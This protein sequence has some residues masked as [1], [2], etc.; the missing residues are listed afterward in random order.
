MTKIGNETIRKYICDEFKIQ[1]IQEKYNIRSKIT[2]SDAIKIFSELENIKNPGSS[3]YHSITSK[4]P[5]INSRIINLLTNSLWKT[6]EKNFFDV[7]TGKMSIPSYR[8]TNFPIP[9]EISIKKENDLYYFNLPMSLKGSKVSTTPKFNLFFGRDRS[10]NKSIVE[11]ILDNTYTL[12]GSTIQLTK[13]ND[14]VL[15]LVFEHSVINEHIIDPNKIMGVDI[16]INR[17]VSFYIPDQKYQ[18]KQIEIGLKIQHERIKL[19]IQ[20]KKLQE[21]NKYSKGGH[22]RNRKNQSLNTHRERESNWSTLM[23]HIISRELIK[24]AQ[25]NNVGLIKLED[26]TGITKN[27]NDSFLKTWKYDQ[28]QQFIKYKA[29]AVGIKVEYVNP[30]NTSITCPTCNNID[31]NN[32]SDKDK[33]IF[34]CQNFLCDD[35]DKIKDADIIGSINIANSVSTEVKLKSKKGKQLKYLKNTLEKI[36]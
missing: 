25:E 32:R 23:N 11:K 27:Q 9:V 20:R 2:R 13:D 29:E 16:G 30:M 22:G 18:P 36:S 19:H 33:T 35:F 8:T 14:F 10:N 24:I 5:F 4:Y 26:L 21:N 1:E 15:N 6:M 34:K 12:K 28:L 31:P 17:P 7:L 3:A